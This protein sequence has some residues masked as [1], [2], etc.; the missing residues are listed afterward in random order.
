MNQ[1][2]DL[3]LGS[4][5]GP[6]LALAPAE[7]TRP[8]LQRPPTE[9]VAPQQAT[10]PDPGWRPVGASAGG[11]PNW[12]PQPQQAAYPPPAWG[13]A[14]AWGGTAGWGGA[15]VHP[16]GAPGDDRGNGL[17]I[18]FPLHSWLHNSG[19]RQGL[20]L[21]VI[22]YALLPLIFLTVLNSSTSLSA[23]G[24]AYSLYVAPLWLIGFWML[25]RPPDRPGRREI[26]IAVAIIV[27]TYVWLNTVTI[28]IN[29]ALPITN[30][31]IGPL[32]ALVIGLNEET[33]KALPVLLAGLILLKVRKVKLDVR[34]WMIFGTIAGLHLRRHRAGHLHLN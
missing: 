15:P 23:P 17:R 19:W 28:T 13:A 10:A 32:S 27:W 30:G 2:L 14:P 29:D 22:V 8:L 31:Q 7:G 5:N 12:A 1:S 4:L 18:L 26:V 9:R 16:P 34:M 11:A 20:R 3:A 25:I 24:W 21:G 6:A 33:T